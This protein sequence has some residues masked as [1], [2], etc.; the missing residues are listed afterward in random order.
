M[1]SSERDEWLKLG[2]EIERLTDGWHYIVYRCLSLIKSRSV[3]KVVCTWCL[4][5]LAQYVI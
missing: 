5:L 4:I 2:A 3:G 1:S